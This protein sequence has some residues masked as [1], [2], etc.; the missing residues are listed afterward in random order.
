MFVAPLRTVPRLETPEGYGPPLREPLAILRKIERNGAQWRKIPQAR[1]SALSQT[2]RRYISM[3]T[4][5]AG[6][7]EHP[8]APFIRPAVLGG[9]PM[10]YW[11]A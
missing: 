8:A 4:W 5:A 1:S 3:Q 9:P 10:R 6:M 7:F 11:V 2:P